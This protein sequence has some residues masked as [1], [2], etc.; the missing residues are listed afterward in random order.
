MTTF[1]NRRFESAFLNQSRDEGLKTLLLYALAMG[2]YLNG[3]SA[4]GGAFGFKLDI[5]KGLEDVKANDKKTNLL[6]YIIEK[7][8]N[9]QQKEMLDHECIQII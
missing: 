8:E 5:V 1:G 9:E 6:M 7:A 4:K 2:N 3:Q